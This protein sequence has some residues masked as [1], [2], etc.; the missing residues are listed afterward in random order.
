L[1]SFPQKSLK[2]NKRYRAPDFVAL[3]TQFREFGQ[4]FSDKPIGR[5]SILT[6]EVKLQRGSGVPWFS[7]QRKLQISNLFLEF[8]G[9][10]PQIVEQAAFARFQCGSNSVFTLLSVDIWFAFFHFPGD[11]SARFLEQF[12]T[13]NGELTKAPLDYSDYCKLLD[14]CVIAPSPMF[15][16]RCRTFKPEFFHVLHQFA[17]SLAAEVKVTT[18]TLFQLREGNVLESDSVKVCLSLCHSCFILKAQDILQTNMEIFKEAVLLHADQLG[19]QNALALG[20][21]ASDAG[22]PRSSFP[23]DSDTGSEKYPAARPSHLTPSGV[24]TRSKSRAQATEDILRDNADELPRPAASK[25]RVIFRH[26]IS[27]LLSDVFTS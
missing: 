20:T 17:A 19:Q 27:F 5:T 1:S 18:H 4:P 7:S 15:T 8:I 23:E 12:I 10:L 22:T 9:H 26:F 16:N 2:A 25:V 24:Q 21:E 6:W 13:E 14:C 3:V 11:Q